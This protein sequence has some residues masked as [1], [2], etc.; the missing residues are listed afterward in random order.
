[1][2]ILML[3]SCQNPPQPYESRDLSGSPF[4]VM[5]DTGLNSSNPEAIVSSGI[6]RAYWILR[7]IAVL[8]IIYDHTKVS[9]RS[10]GS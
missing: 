7:V 8:V 6:P 3:S 10:A 9:T 2:H 5:S 1:M 4:S